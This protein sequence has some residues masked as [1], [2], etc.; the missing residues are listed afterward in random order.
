MDA[1]DFKKIRSSKGSSEED[2]I[3]NYMISSIEHLPLDLTGMYNQIVKNIEER[4]GAKSIVP[5]KVL[6]LSRNGL[7]EDKLHH[8]LKSDFDLLQ[9]HYVRQSLHQSLTDNFASKSW[10]FKQDTVRRT[11]INYESPSLQS[12]EYYL[13]IMSEASC[14]N[15]ER[16]YYAD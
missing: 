5:L 11:F 14:L 6:S 10:Y 1:D 2:K 15:E 7:N 3:N 9:F 13:K 4:Y 12:N 8:I 16:I